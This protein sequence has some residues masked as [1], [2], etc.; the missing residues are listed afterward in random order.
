MNEAKPDSVIGNE[1]KPHNYILRQLTDAGDAAAL[2]NA[3]LDD[4]LSQI[5]ASSE[6]MVRYQEA[7]LEVLMEIRNGQ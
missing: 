4:M 6:A 5:V 7:I 2:A 1:A 3:A